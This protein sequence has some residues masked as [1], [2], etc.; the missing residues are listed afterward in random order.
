MAVVAQDTYKLVFESDLESKVKESKAA[1]A[2]LASQLGETKS[3]LKALQDEANKERYG[4]DPIARARNEVKGLGDAYRA[5]AAE[6]KSAEKAL[7]DAAKAKE[8]SQKESNDLAVKGFQFQRADEAAKAAES[9]AF[10]EKGG[11]ALAS[12]AT[13]ALAAAAAIGVAAAGILKAG[14]S[15]GIEQTAQREKNVA[16]LDKLTGGQGTLAE[17]FSKKL[18]AE[19][20]TEEDTAMARIKGLINAR[21][22]QADTESIFRASA[23]LGEIK[24]QGN[25]EAFISIL[26]KVQEH[27][28]AT[29]KSLKGL[30]GAGVERAAVLDMLKQA[31]E[32]AEEVERRLKAGKVSSEDFA[33]AA[34]AAVS[35]DLGGVAGKGLDAMLNRLKIGFDDLFD[36]F[37]LGPL[38]DAGS[39]LDD[40]LQGDAG[41]ALKKGITEAG[42]AVLGLAKNITAAD[43]KSFFETAGSAASTAASAIK[44]AATAAGELWNTIKQVS[45]KGGHLQD[46]KGSL[47][48]GGTDDQIVHEIEQANK[49]EEIRA[50]QKAERERLAAEAKNGGEKVG[51]AVA[52]GMAKGVADNASKANAAT[53]AMVKGALD[54]GASTAKIKSPSGVAQEHGKFYDEGWERGIEQHADRPARA[55]KSMAA[56][57]GAAG[58]SATGGTAGV[59]PG[60]GAAGGGIIVNNNFAIQAGTPDD[61][62]DALMRAVEELT[63]AVQAL[64]L[65]SQRLSQR[66]ATEGR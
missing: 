21:F 66:D 43:I 42:N 65:R 19:T 34:S 54:A 47:L 12:G 37:D 56:G 53:A 31:G 27:G 40:A 58:A 61:I 3:A 20:G 36:D 22:G 39:L 52:D 33:R 9:A 17:E 49:R 6:A 15:Y 14:V 55:A 29:E 59:A 48:G 1:A 63:P 41:A 50:S 35:K 4:K 30:E 45:G 16:V 28:S 32:S 23:D 10:Y 38:K 64:F 44:S 8:K 7:G 24:G 13:I 25:A 60:G 26:E 62:K 5:A 51:E 57:V 18:A 11:K 2:S 46:D